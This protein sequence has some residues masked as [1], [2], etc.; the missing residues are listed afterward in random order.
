MRVALLILRTTVKDPKA[1]FYI[2]LQ[3]RKTSIGRHGNI[4]MD[5][6]FGKE[7][8]K[9]HA[10]ITRYTQENSE[11]WLIEDNHSLNGTFVNKT[12][13]RRHI[14]RE[15]DE[16][17]FGGGSQFLCGDRVDNTDSAECKYV[18]F[19]L[20]PTIHF[21]SGVDPNA[22]IS[23]SQ[24]SI[25]CPICYQDVISAENLPCGHSFCLHCIHEWASVSKHNYKSCLCPMCRSPFSPSQLTPNEFVV[26]NDELQV[27]SLEGILRDLSITNCK[28]IKGAN[29]FKKWSPKHEHFFWNSFNIVRENLNRKRLFLFLT[30]ATPVYVFRATIKELSQA[31]TNLKLEMPETVNKESLRV[32]LLNYMYDNFDCPKTQPVASVT[33]IS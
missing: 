19:Y 15:G 8:S 5:T 33:H 27:W 2:I 13:I 10:F 16:I 24:T 28:V 23:I 1:P 3:N 17:V 14:L 31:I 12:K 4:V 29:I 6:K 11:I 25:T 26:S 21:A 32:I 22:N 9:V 30:E 7:I 20:P 18:F